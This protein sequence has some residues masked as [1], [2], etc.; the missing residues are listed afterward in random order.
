[1]NDFA[2]PW[3]VMSDF[4]KPELVM[5]DFAKP[6]SGR[7]CFMLRV[8]ALCPPSG[9][10][11]CTSERAEYW[12]DAYTIDTPAL[13]FRRTSRLKSCRASRLMSCWAS[14][15]MS[16]WTSRLKSCWTSRLM[17]CW[18]S[19]LKSCW[20]SRLKSC[21]A[22]R[23]RFRRT[24]LASLCCDH[25]FAR[26]LSVKPEVSSGRFLHA[27]PES[28]RFLFMGRVEDVYPPSG[29]CWCTSE[30]TECWSDAYTIDT[31]AFR[32]LFF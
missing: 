28:G 20:T 1:M 4:V 2:K 3:P 9:V 13:R 5:S 6:K 17:S 16:C 32:F 8:I 21:R 31:P 14:R 27:K 18:T 12:S 26:I 15:I 23:L 30:R 7:F 29:V 22:S 10:C 19:R 25:S 24:S 11:W